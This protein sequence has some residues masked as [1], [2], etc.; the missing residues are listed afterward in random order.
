M[1]FEW[2]RRALSFYTSEQHVR[3][4]KADGTPAGAWCKL[5][6]PDDATVSQFGDQFLISLR[7]G[8]QGHAAGAL[9]A[10]PADAL[11]AVS[12]SPD[13][14][15]LPLTVLFAPSAR[16]ALER[17]GYTATKDKLVLSVLTNPTP[18]PTPTPHP[19]P[20][21]SSNPNQVLSVLNNVKSQLVSLSLQPDGRWRP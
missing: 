15:P 4:R 16:V 17:G 18:T 10:T 2:R 11:L 5:A 20:T 12:R 19:N 9:L 3:R 1:E 21:P 8:W 6:V 14:L 7:S 13:N